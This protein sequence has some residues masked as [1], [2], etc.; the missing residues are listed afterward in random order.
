M[1]H[2]PEE[3][4]LALEGFWDYLHLLAQ[5]QLDPRLR[6]K[7]DAS[8]VV[9]QTLLKAYQA[10]D[11]FRGQGPA[12]LA[13]WLRQIL[14]HTLADLL[15]DHGRAKRD[16]ARERS[17][18]AALEESS[19][20]L[21][22]WAAADQSSPSQQAMRHE[23]SLRLAEALATLP[24]P[25][26]EALV[27]KHCEGWSLDEIAQQLGRSPAAVASLL[28]RGLKQLRHHLQERG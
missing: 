28:R 4:R 2:R 15:R 6:G 21:A 17:L 10:L 12:E 20:R 11:Q 14:A 25:Q 18:E 5:M 23:Q 26:R 13:A 16:V 1:P 22:A 7:W 19:A 8:D 27:L 3:H 24:E 9:Q